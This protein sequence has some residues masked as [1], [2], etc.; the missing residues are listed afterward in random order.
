MRKIIFFIL[1]IYTTGVSSQNYSANLMKYWY[2]RQRFN[3]Y[4]IKTGTNPGESMILS[5]KV[6]RFRNPETKF[7]GQVSSE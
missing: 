3:N 7:R 4:F 5:Q 6:C 2:Y 1:C